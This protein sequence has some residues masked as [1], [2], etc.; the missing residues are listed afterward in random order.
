MVSNY[1]Q[2]LGSLF[3]KRMEKYDV[4]YI[5]FFFFFLT[6]IIYFTNLSRNFFDIALM[7]LIDK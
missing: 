3:S 1:R 2:F 4:S 5:I 7:S 6:N